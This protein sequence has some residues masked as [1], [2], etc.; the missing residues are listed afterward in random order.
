MTNTE[1][2]IRQHLAQ[3]IAHEISLDAF[4]AW[5]FAETLDIDNTS[6]AHLQE[7]VYDIK[8][9]LAEYDHG[10]WSEQEMHQ[11][12]KDLTEEAI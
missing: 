6:D 3:L 11:H 7:L 12:F 5:F 1:H 8:L 2:S 10:D 9:L 4:N